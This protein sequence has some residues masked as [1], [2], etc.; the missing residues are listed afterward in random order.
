MAYLLLLLDVGG[1]RVTVAIAIASKREPSLEVRLNGAIQQGVLGPA[2]PV[3]RRAVAR[4]SMP[5]PYHLCPRRPVN[6]SCSAWW[7][8]PGAPRYRKKN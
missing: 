2:P 6:R 7:R 3:R 8:A 1:Y 4:R 5:S